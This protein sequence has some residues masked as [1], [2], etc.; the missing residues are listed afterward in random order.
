M[1]AKCRGNSENKVIV[2]AYRA[3]KM[4][5]WD[6]K[7]GKNCMAKW[8]SWGTLKDIN[9]PLVGDKGKPCGQEESMGTR[10]RGLT[11]HR[12][13]LPEDRRDGDYR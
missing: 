12:M 1:C 5:V 6:V 4:Y 13:S 7:F 2:F 3:G 9:S 11:K 8:H 10:H